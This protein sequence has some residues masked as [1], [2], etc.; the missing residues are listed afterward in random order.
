MYLYQ[1]ILATILKL[2]HHLLLDSSIIRTGASSWNMKLVLE[3][4]LWEPKWEPS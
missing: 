2:T 4:P 1:A 3:T